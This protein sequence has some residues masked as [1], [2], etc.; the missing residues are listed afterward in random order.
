[1]AGKADI[2]N[3]VRAA[4]GS[5]LTMEPGFVPKRVAYERPRAECT[6]GKQIGVS[7]IPWRHP[8]LIFAIVGAQLLQIGA[9]HIPLLSNVLDIQPISWRGWILVATIALSLVQVVEFFKVVT[10]Y[11]PVRRRV[12]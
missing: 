2:L 3:R 8:F 11:R 10:A 6:V 9:M 1:M 4:L 7:D 5:A 12:T